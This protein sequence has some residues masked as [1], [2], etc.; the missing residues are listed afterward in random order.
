MKIAHAKPGAVANGEMQGL[1]LAN[2]E[3]LRASLYVFACGPW[4]R[5]VFPALLGKRLQTPRRDVFFYRHAAGRC[6]L[7]VAAHAFVGLRRAIARS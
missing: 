4:L 2:G 5:K 3:T 7:F 6:S 1:Q